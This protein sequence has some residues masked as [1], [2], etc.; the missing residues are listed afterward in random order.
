[1]TTSNTAMS[2]LL[3]SARE[4][5]VRVNCTVSGER[6]DTGTELDGVQESVASV[7]V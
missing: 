5:C 4:R 6:V 2:L 1:M 7:A 3:S